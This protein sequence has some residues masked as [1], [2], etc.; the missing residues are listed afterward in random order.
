LA[1]FTAKTEGD[2]RALALVW[3]AAAIHAAFFFA[4]GVDRWLAH[5]ALVDFGL[6]TQVVASAFSGF[7]STFEGVS[8]WAFHFSPILFVCA[9]FVLAAHSG[10]A[11]TAIQS[12]VVALVIPPAYLIARRRTSALRAL[13][14]AG[15]TAIYPPLAGVDFTDF[16]ENGFVPAATLWLLWALDG[17]RWAHA[18]A[19][20]AL[21]LAIKEDQALVMGF[22]GVAAF[23]AFRREQ[24]RSGMRFAG[25]AIVAS[26]AI[27]V[28]YFTLIRPFAD[29]SHQWR[30]TR[31]YAW[32]TED[33]GT[34]GLH[35]LPDRIGYLALALAPLCFLP[36]RSRVFFLALP[37]FAECLLSR[38][39]APYTMGQHYAAVWTPYALAAF[40]AAASRS[41]TYWIGASALL[42]LI[43]YLVANPLHPGYFLRVPG[44]R[45]ARLDAY[46]VRLPAQTRIG[47]QEEAYT[48]LG[49][50]FNAQL[51]MAGEP[52]YVLL[53]RDYPDSVWL[54]WTDIRLRQALAQG[55]Y[56]LEEHSGGIELYHKM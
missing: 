26:L 54:A 52:E 4:L 9:P 14:I 40:I 2:G 33:L 19:F 44:E 30:P 13:A 5:R 50:D 39:H 25:I 24:D 53:D 32:R 51:G 17:K 42:C 36:L 43:A 11:L 56:R 1:V 8:H 35:T 21:T 49:L 41:R 34:I 28:A 12:I 47:T 27:F 15:V 29:P 31:F 7:S 37:G 16:H 55:R 18:Y 46:L 20:L 6:F 38:E 3:I 45:D 22:L 48:H 10:L 23:L